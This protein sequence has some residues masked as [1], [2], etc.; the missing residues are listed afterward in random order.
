MNSE[1]K[2]KWTKYRVIHKGMR[3]RMLC[4]RKLYLF[5]R[6]NFFPCSKRV[7]KSIILFAFLPWMTENCNDYALEPCCPNMLEYFNFLFYLFLVV[8]YFVY[9]TKLFLCLKIV[10][11]CEIHKIYH[12]STLSVQFSCVKYIHIVVQSKEFISS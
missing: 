6:T 11:N 9:F 4:Q 5:Q 8:N 12:L 1:N 10:F 3:I 2:T 7:M